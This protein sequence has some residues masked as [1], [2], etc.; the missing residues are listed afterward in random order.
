MEELDNDGIQE[1]N[2]CLGFLCESFCLRKSKTRILI[3]KSD[4][5]KGVDDA[6]K[7]RRRTDV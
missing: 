1:M 5:F 4:Y 7:V 6:F 3:K 2:F